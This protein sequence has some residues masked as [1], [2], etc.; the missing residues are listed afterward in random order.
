MPRLQKPW[1]LDMIG[2]AVRLLDEDAFR[3]HRHVRK[4]GRRAEDEQDEAEQ[5]E[6]RRERRQDESG[7]ERGDRPVTSGR[8]A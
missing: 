5:H 6:R 7:A 4:P 1:K 8:N 3:V 2:P